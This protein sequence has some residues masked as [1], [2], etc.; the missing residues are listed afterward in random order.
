MEQGRL[1]LEFVP[2]ISVG[3]NPAEQNDAEGPPMWKV[4]DHI[5]WLKE[6]A[7]LGCQTAF[8]SGPEVCMYE[9]IL[10]SFVLELFIEC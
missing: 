5:S 6:E 10:G 3:P 1:G 9:G 7:I 2:L 8:L 4:V